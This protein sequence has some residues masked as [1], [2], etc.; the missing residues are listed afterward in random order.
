MAFDDMIVRNGGGTTPD[1]REIPEEVSREVIDTMRE[2][3]VALS[4]F[5]NKTMGSRTARWPVLDAFPEAFWLEGATQADKDSALKQ[6]TS[7]QWANKYMQAE[8][9]AV[10]VPIP[11]AYRD[12]VGVDLFQEIKPLL[13]EEFGRKLDAAILFGVDAPVSWT[14]AN[15]YA[16]AIAAGNYTTLGDGA[17]VG[18][19]VATVAEKVDE[20]GFDTTAF[21]SRPAFKWTVIKE[22]G[23]DGQP[24]YDA[25]TN[26]LY[27]ETFQQVRNGSWD[28][29]KAQLIGGDFTKGLVGIRQSL[30]FSV[31][32]SAPIFD[33]A[34]NM[35][36]NPFQQD[37]KVLRAVMRVGFAVLSPTQTRVNEV[38]PYPFAVLRTAG[39]PAS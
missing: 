29:T 28:A 20:D 24:I 11:D 1:A 7:V 12:D 21:I 34:G 26:S 5:R 27:G 22:R 17:D 14:D 3:S 38:N 10:L 30:T 31:S 32:D 8:E 19:D 36:Y 2:K 16:K 15:I 39:G 37:G 25:G 6:T 4:L 33:G 23:T 18:V 35:I 9:M 13:A